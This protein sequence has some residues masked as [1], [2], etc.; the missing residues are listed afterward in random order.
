MRILCV[1][2]ALLSITIAKAQPPSL[3]LR[4]SDEKTKDI[5][6]Y[7]ISGNWIPFSNQ[8]KDYQRSIRLKIS[9]LTFTS[10]GI[11][12]LLTTALSTALSGKNDVERTFNYTILGVGIPF[13]MACLVVGIPQMSI[14]VRR[15]KQFREL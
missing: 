13:S 1:F 14:G 7:M 11:A 12:G 10:L 8:E 3:N 4:C 2:F 9:G 15:T 6:Q 5:S